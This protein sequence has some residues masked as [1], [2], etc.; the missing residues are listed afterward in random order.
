M[1]RHNRRVLGSMFLGKVTPKA[2]SAMYEEIVQEA[3]SVSRD[4][5]KLVNSDDEMT[6]SKRLARLSM[7]IG[8]EQMLIEMIGIPS[9][10]GDE[11][12]MEIMDNR[13]EMNTLQRSLLNIG[14]DA[15]KRAA[16]AE[17]GRQE[18][19]ARRGRR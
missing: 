19:L 16:A 12:L 17:K 10:V 4:G 13:V 11:R 18:H 5:W 7:L 3:L 15:E 8:R 1:A 2:G 14:E 6:T 9:P